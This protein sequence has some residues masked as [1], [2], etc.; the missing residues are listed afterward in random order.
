MASALDGVRIIELTQ[1]IA[2]PYTGMLLAE[3]GAEV[4]KVEP[5]QG[6]RARGTPGFHVWNRSKRSIVADPATTEGQEFIQRLASTA[7]VVLSDSQPGDE[8][9]LGLSYEVLSQ[10][11]PGLI[12]CHLPA[13]GSKGPHARRFA[14]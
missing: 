2:G 11:N 1:D 4:I 5:A 7:D 8:A 6:D 12:Y 9:T 10:D 13:F 14:D 3:Q